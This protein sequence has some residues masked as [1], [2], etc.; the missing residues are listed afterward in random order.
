[1][2]RLLS[3]L[4]RCSFI[5]HHRSFSTTVRA[6]RQHDPLR[7]LF[8]GSD[9]FSIASLLSVVD[10]MR[11]DNKIV[12]SIDVLCR[13]DKR[14]GRGLKEVNQGT[15]TWTCPFANLALKHEQFLSSSLQQNSSFQF[16]KSIHSRNSN[17]LLFPLPSIS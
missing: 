8:C 11:Q 1:M 17:R 15:T 10:V 4:S 7:I 12:R 3:I 5:S 16:T 6:A 9:S 2:T 13:T 14:V